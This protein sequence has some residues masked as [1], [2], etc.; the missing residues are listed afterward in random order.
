MD[1]EAWRRRI[2]WKLDRIAYHLTCLALAARTPLLPSFP[3]RPRPRMPL[4][5]IL[6]RLL[7][8][9][10]A[11]LVGTIILLARNVLGRLWDAL[12]ASF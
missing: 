11:P 5:P 9:Y 10:I 1:E 3:P 8:S 7:A 6:V 4:W 2:E 12:L